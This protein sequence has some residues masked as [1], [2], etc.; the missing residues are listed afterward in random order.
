MSPFEQH[1]ASVF[2]A[3]TIVGLSVIFA[4]PSTSESADRN[5]GPVVRKGVFMGLDPGF[6]MR[7][8]DNRLPVYA[9]LDLRVG[10]CLTPRVHL[11]MDWRMDILAGNGAHAVEKRQTIGPVL[12]VFLLRGWFARPYVHLGGAFPFYASLGLQSGYEF[13]WGRFAAAGIAVGGDA[14]IPFDGQPP[15]GYTTFLSV[16]LSA[17]DLGT[18]R[19]RDDDGFE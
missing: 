16:Y 11:G 4:S 19:G 3:V 7:I 2:S 5:G 9:R 8:E 12:T 6:A 18:R 13:S 1:T 17:Y 14:D 10:G 15:L